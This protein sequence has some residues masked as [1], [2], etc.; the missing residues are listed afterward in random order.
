MRD[1]VDAY[2]ALVASD[3]EGVVNVCSG[4]AT[5]LR[6]VTETLVGLASVPVE[7]V[8]DPALERDTDP[9]RVVGDPA[10]LRALTEWTPSFTL[11]QS[12]QDVLDEWRERVRDAE[13]RATV[14][15]G[16]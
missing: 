9:Q 8:H 3:A 12:L 7:L 1:V 6:A 11:E 15:P 2:L 13:P 5:P 14:T 16:A 10:R 4:E